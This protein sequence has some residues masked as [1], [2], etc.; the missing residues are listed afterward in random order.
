MSN[1]SPIVT[2]PL[3]V[4]REGSAS[5]KRCVMSAFRK[6]MSVQT[7]SSVA[8]PEIRPKKR[9]KAGFT[10]WIVRKSNGASAT[11]KPRNVVKAGARMSSVPFTV[12][13]FTAPGTLPSRQV[14]SPR[15]T[16]NRF[17]GPPLA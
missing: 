10:N 13:R 16:T 15:S 9:G 5:S 14:N 1:V 11:S 4:K 7:E 3:P 17:T 12:P 2:R 8:V 6:R